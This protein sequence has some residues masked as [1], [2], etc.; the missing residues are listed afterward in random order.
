MI[1][2]EQIGMQSL[3]AKGGQR[4]LGRRRQPGR[5]GLEAGGV[6]LIAHDRVTDMGQMHADLMRAAGLQPA[7]DEARDR[8]AVGAGV[9]LQ[10]LPMRHRLAAALAH[11]ALLTR[12]GA[13]VERRVDG[14]ARLI[15]RTPDEGEIAALQTA[16]AFVGELLAERTMRCVG[17]GHDHEAAGVLVEPM[18]DARAFHAADAGETVAAMRDQ[19]VDQRA[20]RVSRGGVDDQAGGLVDDNERVVLIDDIERN[21][22]ALRLS[23]FGRRQRDRDGVAGVDGAG[24][25]ADRAR[26][27]RDLTG[28]D[29]GLQ[30]RA[31][32][33]RDARG[34]HA[35]E[36]LALLLGGNGD[37]LGGRHADSV[38]EGSRIIPKSG[39]RF[40]DKI[41]RKQ[42]V[43]AMSDDEKPLDPE[44]AAV[45]A[46]VRRLMMIASATTFIAVAAV[47][48]VIGYRMFTVKD[49]GRAEEAPAAF[50]DVTETLPAGARVLSTAVAA[51]HIVVTI[52]VG[53]VTELRTYDPDTLKPLGRL[54]LQPGR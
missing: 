22:L 29:Q 38:I 42:E 4:G 10:H 8:L 17:L 53:G 6:G 15:G 14:A 47:L 25:I 20:G 40:S 23:R 19:R 30:A 3:P 32:Q 21:G 27:D 26:R 51:D 41:M 48:M 18:H 9:A 1:N 31:R 28:E 11:G 45:V 13:A 44:A 16:F 24:G 52:E 43:Q 35:I 50:A 34:Q 36:P 46:K 5:L 39:D 7:F 49:G 37:G 2:G 33:R 54:R 12:F